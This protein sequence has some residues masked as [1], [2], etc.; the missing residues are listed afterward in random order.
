MALDPR[1]LQAPLGT[2]ATIPHIR[3]DVTQYPA[4]RFNLPASWHAPCV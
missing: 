3:L 4:L 2:A 1:V